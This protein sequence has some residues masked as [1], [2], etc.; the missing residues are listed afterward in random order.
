MPTFTPTQGEAITES[1]EGL[2]TQTPTGAAF[3][4]YWEAATSTWNFGYGYN[5]TANGNWATVL[6]NADVPSNVI[7]L[8]QSYISAGDN[9][10][11]Y[12]VALN[13]ALASALTSGQIS[14]D[15]NTVMGDVYPIYQ[16]DVTTYLTG[17]GLTASSVPVGMQT[18]LTDLW[19]NT[20]GK[21]TG[22]LLAGA[23]QQGNESGDYSAAAYQLAYNTA[24]ATNGGTTYGNRCVDDALTS[25]GLTVT[26]ASGSGSLTAVSGNTS[27]SQVIELLAQGQTQGG[28]NYVASGPIG[29]AAT[30]A[31][32]A[33]G[34][35]Q[36]FTIA[37][38][39]Q[40]PLSALIQLIT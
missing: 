3:G 20:G 28:N 7:T 27:P 12:A 14:G 18:A 26:I 15:E 39:W 23:L 10:S 5:L 21:F 1:F 36:G 37:G 13:K 30:A 11:S 38:G 34:S 31:I 6:G 4:F 17:L 24:T 2:G 22:P 19:Y 9:S 35:P 40:L 16:N 8:A 33:W 25:L 29:T 32:N